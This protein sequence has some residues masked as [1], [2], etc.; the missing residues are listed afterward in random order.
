[1]KIKECMCGDVC[2]CN[3]ETTI[4]EVAK[5][6]CN[7]HIGCIPVCDNEKNVIG[8]LTDR[9]IILR[10]TASGK[11]ASTTKVSDIMTCNTSC[12][13][14]EA[15]INEA[16]DTMIKC[17]IRRIPVTENGKLVG[18]LTL[19]DIAKNKNIE[20]NLVGQTIECICKC[21]DKN[22]E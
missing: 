11:D 22:A 10:H 13:E 16:I 2:Y 5:I 7:N 6:M 1:M 17:Q 21:N 3:A 15:S 12:C 4:E 18:I 20:N 19:G 8:I 14:S 9:D